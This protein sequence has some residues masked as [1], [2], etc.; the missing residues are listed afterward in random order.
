MHVLV[1]GAGI[2][3][4]AAAL[5]LA[6]SG[7]DV[8]VVDPADGVG[9]M[10]RTSTF[11]GRPVD[12]GADAF[13]VRVPHA[14]DLARHIGLG[15]Q[16]VHPARREAHVWHAGALHRL[17]RHVMGVPIDL[18]EVD[19]SGLLSAD[20]MD[21]L[22][23]D[24]VDTATPLPDRDIDIASAI[25]GRIGPEAVS[26]LVDPL[27]G[28]INAGDTARQSLAA[29]VPQLDAARRDPH[30]GSLIQAC[31]AQLEQARAAGADPDAPIFAAPLGG[32]A[33]F[34]TAVAAAA[35][36]TGRVVF[37]QGVALA[38]V[39]PGP[40]VSLSD[41]STEAVDGV[42]VATPGPGVVSA[43]RPLSSEV[44]ELI[45]AVDHVSVAFVRLAF[46][47]DQVGR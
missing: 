22:R 17:P 15:D 6:E 29:V 5:R 18:D 2:T 37:R 41:G 39:E 9:G 23:R 25:S 19:A 24:L 20:G 42:V 28:G 46:R 27:V 31:R 26:L 38:T 11:A 44:A 3:G 32:M 35:R 1:A 4:L 21:R 36:G 47:V 12:E 45:S 40:T 7:A 30:H 33:R 34:P 14:L 10:L 16:L 43:I 13:L 8:T